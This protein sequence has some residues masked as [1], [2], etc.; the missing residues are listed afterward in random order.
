MNVV[1]WP[2]FSVDI[3]WICGTHV[4]RGW[5]LIICIYKNRDTQ[6]PSIQHLVCSTCQNVHVL[7]NWKTTTELISYVPFSTSP[8]ATFLWS[9]PRILNSW[10]VQHWKSTIYG[11]IWQTWLAENTKW[12]LCPCS[13]NQVLLC[14]PEVTIILGAEKKEHSLCGCE[15]LR[16]WLETDRMLELV[17]ACTCE[18]KGFPGWANCTILASYT[19]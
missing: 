12:M 5:L 7:S 9:V 18:S 13:E 16:A 19:F 17:F 11:Q 1:L 8:D 2:F 14:E 15:W 3:F 6:I 10:W 4:N